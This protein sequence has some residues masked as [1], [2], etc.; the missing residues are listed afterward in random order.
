MAATLTHVSK[1]QVSSLDPHSRWAWTGLPKPLP[2]QGWKG[3]T[4]KLGLSSPQCGK[5]HPPAPGRDCKRRWGFH[6][7]LAG[8]RSIFP[9]Q[10]RRCPGRC[11]RELEHSPT[12]W[13]QWRTGGEW[14]WGLS[15]I[16]ARKMSGRPSRKPESSLLRSRNKGLCPPQWRP[17]GSNEAV[18][19]L[20]LRCHNKLV[21]TDCLNK[22][23]SLIT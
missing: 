22:I 14:Y 23:Q 5:E 6:P 9:S 12:L 11:G 1:G 19:T 10:L 8:G 3:P 20:P 2:G 18:P 13:Y 21:K 17:S 4:Q 16:P 7:H 15:P